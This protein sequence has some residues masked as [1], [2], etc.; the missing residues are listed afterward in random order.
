MKL[1]VQGAKITKRQWTA[2]TSPGQGP[3]SLQ[4][5]TNTP[6]MKFGIFARLAGGEANFTLSLELRGNP[7]LGGKQGGVTKSTEAISD[8]RQGGF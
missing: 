8:L 3:S 4:T 1:V 5:Q 2:F 7:D 6:R